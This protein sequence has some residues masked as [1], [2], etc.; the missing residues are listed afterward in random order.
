MLIE[1][2][3][4]ISGALFGDLPVSMINRTHDIIL[5]FAKYK[6]FISGLLLKSFIINLFFYKYKYLIDVEQKKNIYLQLEK[7]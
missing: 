4:L 7:L 2:F 1:I 6:I 3:D 5:D